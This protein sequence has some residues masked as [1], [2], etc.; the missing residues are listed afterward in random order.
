MADPFL[1]AMAHT[2]GAE[3]GW[4]NDPA[5]RGGPTNLGITLRTLKALLG[6]RGDLDGDG[7]VDAD[8]LRLLTRES[9]TAIYRE[10]YW[11]RP[12]L[13]S[14]KDPRVAGKVFDFGVNAGPRVSIAHLQLAINSV[15]PA[16]VRPVDVDGRLGA[17]TLTAL[18]K[19][20]QDLLI[21]A[22]IAEQKCFYLKLVERDPTQGKFLGGWLKRAAWDGASP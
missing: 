19:C 1:A 4:A 15:R 16:S 9:A 12:G 2:F 7:H 3:G 17:Q 13:F 8:D 22:L 5:D 10:H 20:D 11:C 18:D 21:S 14:I 6:E